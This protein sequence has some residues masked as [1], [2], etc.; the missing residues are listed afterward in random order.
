LVNDSVFFSGAGARNSE[1]GERQSEGAEFYEFHNSGV[2]NRFELLFIS[3]AAKG[4]LC[5]LNI[6]L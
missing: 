4:N 6:F 1:Y 2:E 5:Y 3:K